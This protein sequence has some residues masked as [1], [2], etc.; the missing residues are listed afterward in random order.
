MRGSVEHAALEPFS[1]RR[2]LLG[3]LVLHSCEWGTFYSKLKMNNID[4]PRNTSPKSDEA[5]MDSCERGAFLC[6]LWCIE[7]I[8]EGIAA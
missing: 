8:Q 3:E 1:L 4:I 5:G 6:R 2:Y 7:G